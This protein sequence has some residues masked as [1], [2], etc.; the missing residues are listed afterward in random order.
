MQKPRK[1]MKIKNPAN[2]FLTLNG[3]LKRDERWMHQKE[4]LFVPWKNR[5]LSTCISWTP[6][7]VAHSQKKQWKIHP[8]PEEC[9]IKRASGKMSSHCKMNRIR[10]KFKQMYLNSYASQHISNSSAKD[11]SQ[12]NHSKIDV[13]M[14]D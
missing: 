4:H 7:L 8:C 13:L 6:P 5:L 9:T 11:T 14:T 3:K 10:S 12:P 2:S 1:L